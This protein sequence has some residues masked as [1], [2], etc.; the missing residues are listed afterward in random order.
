MEDFATSVAN[1]GLRQLLEVALDG[2]GAFRR[3]KNVLADHPADRGRW[4]AFR[5][6][7]V[8]EAMRDWLESNDITALPE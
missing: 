5:A 2:S 6:E 1:P 3:F 4:F 8:R 7:R